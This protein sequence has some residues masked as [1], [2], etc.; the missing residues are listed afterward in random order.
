MALFSS[1]QIDEARENIDIK[2]DMMTKAE[3]TLRAWGVIG[4]EDNVRMFYA[5]KL[6]LGPGSNVSKKLWDRHQ[7]AA[8]SKTEASMSWHLVLR[9]DLPVLPPCAVG[10]AIDPTTI[11]NF[12]KGV[13]PNECWVLPKSVPASL[14]GDHVGKIKRS[15]AIV[16]TLPVSE[17]GVPAE[18]FTSGQDVG[19]LVS[20]QSQHPTPGLDGIPQEPPAKRARTLAG[21]TSHSSEQGQDGAEE[22]WAEKQARNT[23][24]CLAFFIDSDFSSSRFS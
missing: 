13:K 3:R 10:K 19:S 9:K 1:V 12:P 5:L 4:T 15:A 16:S 6:L 24:A 11:P 17:Y 8:E 20:G 18:A 21:H 22:H 14:L 7:V 23:E 2:G